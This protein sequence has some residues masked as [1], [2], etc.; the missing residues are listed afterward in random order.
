MEKFKESLGEQV[1]SLLCKI[2]SPKAGPE[3]KFAFVLL[4]LGV[5]GGYQP[6][7]LYRLVLSFPKTGQPGAWWTGDLF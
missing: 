2:R 3:G 6:L 1:F 5:R 7:L 4:E